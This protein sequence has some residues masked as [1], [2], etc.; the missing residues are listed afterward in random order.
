MFVFLNDSRR[1]DFTF[2]PELNYTFKIKTQT[3]ASADTVQLI[4]T[5]HSKKSD[6][7]GNKKHQRS[8]R[9]SD[10]HALNMCAHGKSGLSALAK[11]LIYFPVSILTCFK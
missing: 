6:S 2:E 7:H 10:V 1:A 3:Q 4:W 8:S 11:K 9:V 5:N